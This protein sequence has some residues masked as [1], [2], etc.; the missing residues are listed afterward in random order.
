MVTAGDRVLLFGGHVFNVSYF[1]DVWTWN[2]TRWSRVDRDPT[3]RGRG[4]AATVWDPVHKQL[5]VF[6]GNLLR[7]DAG[8]GNLGLPASDAWVLNNGRWSQLAQGPP[9]LVLPY[10]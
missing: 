5:F 6:G 8:P 1:A 4:N 3:P 2:G 9:A 10:G 7:P